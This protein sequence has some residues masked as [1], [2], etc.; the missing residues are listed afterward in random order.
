MGCFYFSH[1]LG[2]FQGFGLI[3]AL[4]RSTKL[5]ETKWG[6]MKTVQRTIATTLAFLAGVSVQAHEIECMERV[7]HG[8][9]V[10]VSADEQ[11]A[12]VFLT[13]LIEVTEIAHLRCLKANSRDLSCNEPHIADAGYSVFIN[14][15]RM[16]AQLYEI[17]L[18][19]STVKAKLH[20]TRYQ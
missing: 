8:Y 7:D 14:T 12:K 2:W 13:T 10:V 18:L 1:L 5:I 11:S 3:E 4:N 20:C 9:S 16:T 17:T 6:I 15:A 19:G